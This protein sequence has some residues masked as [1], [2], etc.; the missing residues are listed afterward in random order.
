MECHHSLSHKLFSIIHCSHE[1]VNTLRPHRVGHNRTNAVK[2]HD[3]VN[4]HHKPWR[5]WRR[6]YWAR[7]QLHHPASKSQVT[8]RE[9]SSRYREQTEIF[10]L[11]WYWIKTSN[12]TEHAASPRPCWILIGI[13]TCGDYYKRAYYVN[14]C[15]SNNICEGVFIY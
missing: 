9:S 14:V 10:S 5:A 8:S 15:T 4:V 1:W 12:R 6:G 11:T 13:Q 2:N 7:W 3:V